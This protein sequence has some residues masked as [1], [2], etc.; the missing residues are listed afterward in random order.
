MNELLSFVTVTQ[1][2]PEFVDRSDWVYLPDTVTTSRDLVEFVAD[3]NGTV[4][5]R[6]WQSDLPLKR[7]DQDMVNSFFENAINDE[8]KTLKTNSS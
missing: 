2:E 7:I 5:H 4:V 1:S 6:L 3:L 8:V